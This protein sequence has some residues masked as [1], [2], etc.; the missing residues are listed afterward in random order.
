MPAKR[1]AGILLYRR[2][3]GR[4]E[5]LLVH[6]GGPFWSKKDEGAWFIPKGEL[7]EGEQPLSAAMREFREELGCEPPS[8]EPLE[9]GTVKNKSGK[10]IYAWALQGDINLADFK[11]NTFTLEWPPRSGK[12]R[13]FPELDRAAFFALA[14]AAPKLHSAELPLL[15]RLRALLAAPR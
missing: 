14:D 13:E 8:G 5:V 10:L 15:E 4:I 7:E 1:S 6:L 11:S 9:L 2:Q 12:M 3:E